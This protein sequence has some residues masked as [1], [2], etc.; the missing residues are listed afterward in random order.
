M[1]FPLYSMQREALLNQPA[2]HITQAQFGS[3]AAGL[4]FP[5]KAL[6]LACRQPALS[7]PGMRLTFRV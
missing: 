6:A 5:A 3:G 2:M 7:G 1:T 4:G